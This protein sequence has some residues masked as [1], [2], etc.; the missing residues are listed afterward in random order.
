M[1]AVAVGVLLWGLL[2]T[3]AA[4]YALRARARALLLLRRRLPVLSFPCGSTPCV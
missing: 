4:A 1:L 2:L 3:A